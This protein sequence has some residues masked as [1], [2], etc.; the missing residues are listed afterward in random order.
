[1][2]IKK[3]KDL[4]QGIQTT[5]SVNFD[6]YIFY[7]GGF[8]GGKQPEQANDEI[9]SFWDYA[10]PETSHKRGF[11]NDI[12]RYSIKENKWENMGE[13]KEMK[14]RQSHSLIKIKNKIF[15][16][17][18]FSYS[19]L[20]FE[21][22]KE[23]KENNIPLPDKSDTYIFAD[24]FCLEYNNGNLVFKNKG[25]LP[26][27]VLKP[28]LKYYNNKIYL[29]SGSDHDDLAFENCK[30]KIIVNKI[31]ILNIINEYSLHYNNEFIDIPGTTN[32][33]YFSCELYKDNIYIFSGISKTE[34]II[35]YAQK[36]NEMVNV[37]DNWKYDLINKKWEII[38]NIPF[39]ITNT[40][41]VI[42]NNKIYFFGGAKLKNSIFK[43]K[44]NNNYNS[45]NET[46]I[47][48]DYD[49]NNKKKIYN[50]IS[51]LELI[52]DKSFYSRS[53]YNGYF[54]NIIFSYNIDEK[55]Y[56]IE[57]ELPLQ[58]AVPILTKYYNKKKNKNYIYFSGNECNFQLINN[59]YYGVHSSL[60]LRIE[61]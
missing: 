12:W 60:F 7:I 35:Q 48:K 59:Y 36:K 27:Q 14:P 51:S 31:L 45:L 50:G 32:R 25:Y 41:S 11:F 21:E 17:G 38:E 44:I 20:S 16:M 58:C 26:G 2:K 3:K 56:K 29:F 18:G 37:I 30:N 43:N 46:K 55:K 10:N 4:M 39:I 1:M 19:P 15:I 61:I 23:Y 52:K 54:G 33:G 28:S 34:K 5:V 57:G 8:C 13:L 42:L 53:L 22:I 6:D 40:S 9:G 49:P 47:W 24:Y